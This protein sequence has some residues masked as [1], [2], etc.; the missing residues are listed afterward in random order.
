MSTTT[1]E[2]PAIKVGTLV[3]QLC[4]LRDKKRAAQAVVDDLEKESR[5][6]EQELL[7]VLEEQGLDKASGKLATVSRRTSQVANVVDW[8]AFYSFI[9]RHKHYHLLQRRVSDP[10]WRELMERKPVPGTEAFTKVTLGLT[11]L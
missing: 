1:P 5:E 8:D 11:S 3:D 9:H 6:K 2:K 4:K 10:A 7:S